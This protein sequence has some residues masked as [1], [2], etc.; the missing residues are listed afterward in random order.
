MLTPIT[1]YFGHPHEII[2][3][4]I[5]R[6]ITKV[7]TR[8][9][10]K[11]KTEYKKLDK[12]AI[13]NA[14][15]LKIQGSYQWWT[16]GAL[17]ELFRISPMVFRKLEPHTV[18]K[19]IKELKTLD[20]VMVYQI[21]NVIGDSK[22][23]KDG[24]YDPFFDEIDT[25]VEMSL[26]KR[27]V[28]RIKHPVLQFTY[29]EINKRVYFGRFDFDL[30]SDIYEFLSYLC[31]KYINEFIM[32][33]SMHFGDTDQPSNYQTLIQSMREHNDKYPQRRFFTPLA[34]YRLLQKEQSS[35]VLVALF[36]ENI[37]KKS[38]NYR[39]TATS[40]IIELISSFDMDTI[41]ASIDT[42][43]VENIPKSYPSSMK[44]DGI[45]VKIDLSIDNV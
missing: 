37:D 13:I 29:S 17:V 27:T 16:V 20:L 34:K 44:K 14:L 21:P 35:D 12:S 43:N 32:H 30:N 40:F 10:I 1:H 45:V 24:T 15:L 39:L 2:D 25:T 18:L 42:I 4:E 11:T 33:V 28:V 38:I 5:M 9:T 19:I 6:R 41:N 3:P 36:E 31:P 7:L 26:R 8:T 22:T 23:Y